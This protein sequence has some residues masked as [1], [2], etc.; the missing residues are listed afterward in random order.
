MAQRRVVS[1]SQLVAA[2]VP[3]WLIRAEVRAGRWQLVG[4]QVVVLHNGPLSVGE[5]RWVAV[6]GTGPRAALDGVSALQE[7]GVT[8]LDDEVVHVIAPKSSQP[9]RTAGVLVHESRR[10]CEDDVITVG[11]RRVRPAVAAVHAALWAVSDRQAQLFLLMVVQQR[12]ASP[13]QVLEAV[14]AVRRHPRRR[15][16]RRLVADLAGGVQSL[17]ELDVAEDFR[18]RG[19]PEPDRQ[20]IR[21]R[22]SG[23]Q[24]LDCELSAYGLVFEIDGVGHEDPRQ[25]LDDLLRDI[26]VAADAQ[27]TIRIPLVLYRLDRE[28]VLDR[29][30]ALLVARGWQP[31]AVAS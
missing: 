31:A 2:R 1:R 3:R 25:Q 8:G 10:F 29:I 12:K 26:D 27:T 23:T 24:Y 30:E 9:R 7:A 17:G 22:P 14:E 16:L 4:R 13:E 19:F 5:L 11:I 18:R 15:L 21:R 28:R 6:L 20:E